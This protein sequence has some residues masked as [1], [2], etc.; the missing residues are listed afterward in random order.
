MG[1]FIVDEEINY[2]S[3][4]KIQQT[5]KNSSVLTNIKPDFYQ[6]LSEYIDN[7]DT[8]LEKESS[9]QK[10]I[11]IK[12]ELQNIKKIADNIYE[13]R[14]KKILLLAI[15]KVRGGAPDLKNMIS[16]EKD[17]FESI[18]QKML[19]SRKNIFKKNKTE[20]R[21]EDKEII[22]EKKEKQIVKVENKKSTFI[23]RVTKEVP[24]FIGTDEQKYNLRINDILSLPENMKDTLEKR[25]V[26]E[27]VEF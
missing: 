1:D 22:E 18:Y 13:Q 27:K 2:K 9:D 7:L 23:A 16:F 4:R 24:E 17:L 19:D 12:D 5:E 14:E 6:N 21:D 26:I 8:R 11:L 25:G 15:S 20:R 10:K 3:L